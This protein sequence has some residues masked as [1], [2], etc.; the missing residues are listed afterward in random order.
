M[1]K[2]NWQY[3][4]AVW[5]GHWKWVDGHDAGLKAH[6]C[7]PLRARRAK[8]PPLVKWQRERDRLTCV[9]ATSKIRYSSILLC[10][11]HYR[12]WERDTHT[13]TDRERQRQIL[14]QTDRHRPTDRQTGTERQR[15]TDTHRHDT[16]TDGKT[17]RQTDR[18]TEADR[19]T[20]TERHR[21]VCARA[22]QIWSFP[23]KM[24]FKKF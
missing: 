13:H 17:E 10:V 2:R 14:R 23:L 1:H 7:K 3:N 6:N 21:N 20:E 9:N 16:Q 12:V 18:E 8:C 15:Q 4:K 11:N 24:S 22:R 19:Q 5:P